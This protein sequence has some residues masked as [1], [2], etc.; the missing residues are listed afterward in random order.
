MSEF[1]NNG[2]EN[3]SAP[4][5]LTDI[6]VNKVLGKVNDER[7][8]ANED[9]EHFTIHLGSRIVNIPKRSI[10]HIEDKSGTIGKVKIADYI[11]EV[12]DEHDNKE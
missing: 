5:R 10:I 12:I 1:S 4:E 8:F 9:I 3:L 6:E 7:L 11:R 2:L